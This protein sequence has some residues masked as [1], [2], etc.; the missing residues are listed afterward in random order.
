MSLY[1]AL[2]T[3]V[4]GLSANGSALSVI[5][6]NIANVNTTGYKTSEAEFS[7]IL[8]SSTEAGSFAAGG[9]RGTAEQLISRQGLLQTSESATDLALSGSGFFVVTEGPESNADKTDLL[10]T[11]AGSFTQDANGFLRNS[12]GYYL[13]GWRLDDAGALPA[14][15]NTIQ[16]I[17]LN[18]LTGTASATTQ[19]DLRA[20][21]QASE[22]AV[23]GYVAG[24]INS[25][26]VT[27]HF[28]R[29]L[30]AFD[31]QGGAQPIR[32]AFVKTA[33]NTWSYEAIYDGDAANIGGAVNNPV[34]TGT[35]TFDGD[36]TLLTP[37]TG[38]A[39]ITVP[40]DTAVTGLAPQTITLNFGTVGEPNGL[41]QFDS[42]STLISSGVNGALFGGISG[43]TVDDNG[44]VTA[45]FDNGVQRPVFQLPVA[46]FQNPNGLSGANGN[47]YIRTDES[48]DVTLLEA[49]TGGAG[50][51]AAS[52]LEAS[53]VDL[54][55]EF[56]KLIT[57]QRAY[58]AASRII[59]TSDQMLEELI[60]IKR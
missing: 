35:I 14:N 49:N 1:G 57:T 44:V 21:L 33:S 51:V 39:P 2:F 28:E 54:A 56:T 3:G 19:V 20:N 60:R 6:N 50:A 58:S 4:S 13:Q 42:D 24:Q 11:R 41:T 26:A 45:L 5:S 16:P 40:F 37:A 31:T 43:V 30:E 8:A 22:T 12:A 48:G 46:M 7:T 17:N 59:T 25:G 52:A 27:P 15:R 10:Y 32:L 34:A 55:E 53:T 29:T 36:G 18:Q 9:V 47:A 23:A 38:T